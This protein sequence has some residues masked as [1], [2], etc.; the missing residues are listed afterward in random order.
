MKVDSYREGSRARKLNHV[1]LGWSVTCQPCTVCGSS[2]ILKLP[3][4][5]VILVTIRVIVTNDFD[6]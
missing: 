1:I 4:S 3:C 5:S 6:V 2:S